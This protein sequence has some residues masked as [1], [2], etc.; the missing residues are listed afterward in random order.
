MGTQIFLTILS[1]SLSGTLVGILIICARPLTKKIFSQKWNYYVWL[2][3]IVRLLIPFSLGLNLVGSF[4][5][6]GN[7]ENGP[8]KTQGMRTVQTDGEM[9]ESVETLEKAAIPESVE[10]LGKAAV[11]ESVAALGEMTAP[12]KATMG[13]QTDFVSYLWVIWLFGAVLSFCVKWNDYRN[14]AAY[15]KVDR[16]EVKEGSIQELMDGLSGKLGMKKTVK[17][18]KSSLISGPIMMGI[19]HPCIMLPKEIAERED[20]SLILHHELVHYKKKDLWYKWLYQAVLCIH[21]FNPF[22]YLVRRKLDVDCEL[23]C[24]EE[25]LGILSLEGRKAYGNVLLDAAEHKIGFKKNVLS[26][27]LLEDKSTLKERLN[28]ILHYKK[29]KKIIAAVS[30]CVLALFVLLAGFAGAKNGRVRKG[31]SV[32]GQMMAGSYVSGWES[33]ADGYASFWDNFGET[34]NN[35]WD[36]I[37]QMWQNL[38]DSL[39]NIADDAANG[40]G[41]GIIETY[42]NQFNETIHFDTHGEAWNLYENDRLIAGKDINDKWQAYS[43]MGNGVNVDCKKLILNGSDTYE[44]L[45]AKEAFTQRLDFEAKLLSGKMKLVHVGADGS[46]TML[47]ELDE[48]DSVK[49]SL[50]ISLTEG[51][52]AVKIVGQGAKI[53]S[54]NLRFKNQNHQSILKLFGDEVQETA[55]M[56]LDDFR[57]GDI[58]LV[59]FMDALPYMEDDDVSECAKLL[60]ESD[61]NL[62]MEQIS[63]IILYGNSADVGKYLADAVEKGTRKPLNGKEITENLIYYINSA[64]TV[65]LV[66]HMEEPLDFDML[67]ELLIYLNEKDGEKCLE[68][69]LEQGNKLSYEQF[70]DISPYLSENVIRRLDE[71]EK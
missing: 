2:V 19:L 29:T 67:E 4:F 15:V 20:I 43:Y 70:S 39:A 12:K 54:L 49:K 7:M 3:M 48:G 14:F 51:R 5:A 34:V 6:M 40:A 26:T 44:V 57:K 27:T 17:V 68:I 55:E 53:E 65:R 13:K 71:W 28:A 11:P 10:T 38:G 18:Y 61:A 32:S 64:D 23:A 37:G 16:Q 59:R 30:A 36:G 35:V 22:L 62:T 46:V 9:P 60:F 47:T 63:G 25:V 58:D 8:V 33:M 69:Y 41:Q 45:Y 42:L 1:L 66:E 52:N 24:D 50:D 21:W 56:I 31:D